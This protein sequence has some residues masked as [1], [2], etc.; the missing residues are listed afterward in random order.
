MMY[1]LKRQFAAIA[2]CLLAVITVPAGAVAASAIIEEAK[3]QCIVGEQADGYLGIVS[4]ASASDAV[5]REVRDINQQR[6]S[7]Y[8]DIARRNGVSIEVTA[9]L[10]AQKLIDQARSGQCVRDQNGRWVKV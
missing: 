3:D 9:T 10:T 1:F 2:V 5:R 6:K 7:Y 4:G 8:A